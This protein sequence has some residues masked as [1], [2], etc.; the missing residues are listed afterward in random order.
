[1][2][3]LSEAQVI[4]KDVGL[5]TPATTTEC[6]CVQGLMSACAQILEELVTFACT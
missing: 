1:M 3:V 6:F 4:E 2:Y 5:C